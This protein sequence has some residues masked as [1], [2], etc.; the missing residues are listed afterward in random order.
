MRFVAASRPGERNSR[1]F[2]AA[3]RASENGTLPKL[4][5]VLADAA[6]AAGLAEDEID[7]VFRSAEGR[8]G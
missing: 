5:T 2:W 7:A 6:L 1:L 8:T 4:H 3:C